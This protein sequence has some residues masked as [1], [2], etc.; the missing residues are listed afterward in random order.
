MERWM[1]V[2][3]GGLFLEHFQLLNCPKQSNPYI[4]WN[5]ASSSPPKGCHLTHEQSVSI[6]PASWQPARICPIHMNIHRHDP[7]LSL[8]TNSLWHRHS[9]QAGTALAGITIQSQGSEEFPGMCRWRHWPVCGFRID[10]AT[11]CWGCLA[12][13]LLGPGVDDHSTG[14]FTP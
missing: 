7:G 12:S 6:L 8:F 2:T 14:E 9:S 10:T 1:K 13:H 3:T 11:T 4:A 5:S